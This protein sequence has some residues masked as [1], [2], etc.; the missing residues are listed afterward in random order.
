MDETE[1]TTSPLPEVE[2]QKLLTFPEAMVEATLGKRIQRLAWPKDEY[3]YFKGF[4]DGEFLCI[5]KNG[6]ECIWKLSKG[7]AVEEDYVSF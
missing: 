3:G 5:F 6:E 2:V 1:Q 4:D 7:D